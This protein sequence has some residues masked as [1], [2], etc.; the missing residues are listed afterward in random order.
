M[1]TRTASVALVVLA[2]GVAA[3]CTT[4]PAATPLWGPPERVTLDAAGQEI[5]YPPFAGQELV[6]TVDLSSDGRFVVFTA[7]GDVVAGPDEAN[8]RNAYVRDTLAD[9]TVWLRDPTLPSSTQAVSRALLVSGDGSTVI[10]QGVGLDGGSTD[11]IFAFDR[12]SESFTLLDE[13]DQ[14]EYPEIQLTD[15]TDDGRYVVGTTSNDRSVRVLDTSAGTA[16]DVYAPAGRQVS[17]A[18]LAAGDTRIV[19]TDSFPGAPATYSIA[20]DGSDLHPVGLGA[21][22]PLM[23]SRVI[24]SGTSCLLVQ[25]QNT[26]GLTDHRFVDL[27]T[28]ASESFA[29]DVFVERPSGTPTAIGDFRPT[30]IADDCR[31]VIGVRT[32]QQSIAQVDLGN[33]TLVRVQQVNQNGTDDPRISN[34]GRTALVETIHPLVAQDTNNGTDGYIWHR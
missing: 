29:T 21:G 9:D 16:Q 14:F 15:V 33:D 26:L 4:P 34:D 17:G 10:V 6:D 20:L 28:G 25:T 5:P 3:G 27:T 11:G 23:S 32:S 2:I 19:F 22:G 31:T 18:F 24:A 1:S 8:V 12:A 7:S 30:D 13:S